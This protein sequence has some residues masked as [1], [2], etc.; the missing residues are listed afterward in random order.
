MGIAPSTRGSVTAGWEGP[1]EQETVESYDELLARVE[2]RAP[3]FGGM[4]IGQD[5]RLAVYL[6]DKS[7][8]A[9][10]RSA[11]EIVFGA[12]RLPASGVRALRG[13]YTVSQLKRWAE[14]ATEM[15]EV[16]GVTMVDLDE[17]KNRVAIGIEDN[18]RTRT[19]EQALVSLGIPRKAVV[20][21]VTGQI[22][23]LKPTQPESRSTGRVRRN[24]LPRPPL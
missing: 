8:L 9:A 19:V 12:E 10:A 24:L 15:L 3:G 20:I 17:A 16:S 14:R 13:Q 18:S 23:P 2:E 22:R 7:Q 21:A 5:G 1:L 11:I 4:F 6:L